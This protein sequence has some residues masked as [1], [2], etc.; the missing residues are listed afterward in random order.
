MNKQAPLFIYTY[1]YRLEETEL[2]LLEM[3]SF[4]GKHTEAGLLMSDIAVHPDRSPFMRERIEVM[5]EG[6]HLEQILEQVKQIELNDQTFKVI[7][8]KMNDLAPEDKIEF[9]EQRSIE[10]EIGVYIEGEADV[11]QP[12]NVF[13]IV[14][15][16][17][18]WYFGSYLKSKAVWL[19]HMQKP[20]SYSI[21]LST[22]VA[23][24][25]AN[26]AVPVPANITAIDPCCGIGT[27]LVEA[28]SMDINM[29][30]RDINH[31]VVQG[32]RENLAHFHFQTEVVCGDISEVVDH[33]DTAVVDMPYNHFS[34]TTPEAQLSLLQHTR[35]IADRAVIV[36]VGMI[37]ELIASAGFTIVDRC[38]TRKGNFIRQIIVCV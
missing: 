20:R 37:D 17:G 2:C 8:I 4:F 5:Y 18:R 1:G 24:A 23:R 3:R 30:G 26:I 21:A 35:R 28:L 32:T 7:F 16:G 31:F 27:V 12:D 33:Y 34:H 9:D 10:R 6:D 14:T 38:T 11:R 25:V 36:T 29:I 19:T 15:W 13:G 22:R